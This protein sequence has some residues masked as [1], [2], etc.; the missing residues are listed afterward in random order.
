VTA[1]T[2]GMRSIA[3]LFL[4]AF[5]QL[6]QAQT[7][8]ILHSFRNVAQDGQF[9]SAGVILGPRR[10]LYGTAFYGGTFNTGTI[11]KLSAKGETLLYSF[12]GVHGATPANILRDPAGNI[13][14]ITADGGDLACNSGKGCGTVFELLANGKEIVLHSFIQSATDG[15]NPT[16]LIRDA[17]GN[18]YGTTEF[19][20]PANVGTVFKIDTSGK[21]SVLYSFTGGTGGADGANPN[22]VILDAAGNLY[23]TTSFG[24]P[25]NTGVIFKIDSSGNE[26][27]LYTFTGGNGS[28]DGKNP[29][30]NLVRDAAGNL[31]GTTD[32]GGTA[33]LG[34]LFKLD[35]TRKET[36]LHNFGFP[37]DGAY[38]GNLA[39]DKAGN[40]YGNT[41]DGGAFVGGVV[42]KFDTAGNETI[43][44][45]FGGA[46][47]GQ[48][49]Q[50][51]LTLDSVGH[52][53]GVTQ[54]GGRDGW[55]TVFVIIP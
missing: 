9:P 25:G 41:T 10:T 3:L 37:G 32:I 1:K 20:G 48:Y 39:I 54:Q 19:G 52:I 34:T 16:S 15:G 44:H 51:N 47:D 21:E 43:L 23:G 27:V 11:F 29:F 55:G 26:T 6:V 30:G 42:Y 36:I 46:G 53:Y 7:E 22:G 50:G 24:G 40:L 28:A 33:N 8:K 4:L 14:G 35:T 31:Y 13:Y 49:P 2:Q 5:V 38:P 18:L 17:I 45:N 12:A